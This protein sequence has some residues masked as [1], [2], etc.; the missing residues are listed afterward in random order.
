MVTLR[1]K[2]NHMARLSPHDADRGKNRNRIT[3]AGSTLPTNK[4]G[5]DLDQCFN[6]MNDDVSASRC[7]PGRVTITMLAIKRLLGAFV[8][9]DEGVLEDINKK[10][11]GL[12]QV[13]INKTDSGRERRLFVLAAF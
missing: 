6:I 8:K 3:N 4:S 10:P 7:P 9:P 1:A 5:A 2:P 12:L 13:V 11:D